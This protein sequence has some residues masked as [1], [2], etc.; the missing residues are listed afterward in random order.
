M[1]TKIVLLVSKITNRFIFVKLFI[2][3]SYIFGDY[4]QIHK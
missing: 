3:N 1:E 2:V 4:N